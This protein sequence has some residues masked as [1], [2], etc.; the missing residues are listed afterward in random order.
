MSVKCHATVPVSTLST[1][2]DRF[3]QGG[4]YL[5]LLALFSWH[6][7][8]QTRWPPT[9]ARMRATRRRCLSGAATLVWGQAS[10]HFS[11]VAAR[12]NSF[13]ERRPSGASSPTL[14]DTMM[15]RSVRRHRPQSEPAPHAVATCWDVRAPFW[16][17]FLTA[18]FVT[19][20]HRHTNISSTSVATCVVSSDTRAIRRPA[21]SSLGDQTQSRLGAVAHPD[22]G[23]GL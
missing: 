4:G 15:A 18:W 9:L 7:R 14:A 12:A 8:T 3:I 11:G 16:T 2:D 20:R 19:P 17:A 6:P 21:V 5:G 23:V 13:G 10:R 22:A 1:G